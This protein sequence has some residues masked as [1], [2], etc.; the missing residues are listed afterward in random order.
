MNCYTHSETP[1]VGICKSCGRG[2]CHECVL[3]DSAKMRWL[4]LMLAS[5]S[6][7]ITSCEKKVGS[8]LAGSWAMPQSWSMYYS[9]R[10]TASGDY[11]R[12]FVSDMINSGEIR[13]NTKTGKYEFDGGWLTIPVEHKYKDGSSHV[14]P[15]KFKRETINDVEV[16]LREDAEV[17]WK[18]SRMIY[19][20]GLLIKVSDDPNYSPSKKE[21]KTDRLFRDGVTEWSREAEAAKEAHK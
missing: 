1:A 18:R 6:L 12:G 20:G 15:D 2:L 7:F 21:P 8:D 9:L 17:I 3:F 14:F 13:E 10:L 19:T 4:T 16:L 5:M 11:T